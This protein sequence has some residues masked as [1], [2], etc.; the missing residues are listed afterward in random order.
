MFEFGNFFGG[1]VCIYFFKYPHISIE[2]IIYR[3]IL[4]YLMLFSISGAR[5]VDKMVVYTINEN[6][7]QRKNEYLKVKSHSEWFEAVITGVEKGPPPTTPQT[8]T[9]KFTI[10]KRE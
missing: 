10:Y 6:I 2:L 1:E 3:L 9:A 8:H 4:V 5:K 7:L